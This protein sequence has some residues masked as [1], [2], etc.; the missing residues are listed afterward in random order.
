MNHIQ[1]IILAAGKSTRFNTGRTK[2]AEKICGQEII[3][4][5]TTVF[6]ELNVPTT[7]VVGY[8]QDL[9][10]EIVHAH[11]GPAFSF[12]TQ[13]EQRGSWDALQCSSTEW[14]EDHIIIMNGD[15]PLITPEIIIKLYQQHIQ[16]DADLTFASAHYH[17]PSSSYGRIVKKNGLIS[18][19]EARDF[20]GDPEED[21]C[22][23]AGIYLA[24]KDFLFSQLNQIKIN[25]TSKEFYITDLIKNASLEGKKVITVTVPFDRIRGVNTLEELWASEQIKRSEIIRHWM[26]N[27]VR[28][29]GAQNSHIDL[30]VKIGSGTIIEGGVKVRGNSVIGQNSYIGEFSS[31]E[32]SIIEDDVTI[33]A[34]CVIKHSI[35]RKQA[36]VGPFAHL[37]EH[38]HIGNHAVI[39]NFVEVK[40]ST[41]QEHSKAKHLSYIGDTQ[42]GQNVNI[43]AGTITA[44]FDGM[45]KQKT[46]VQD[47]AYIGCNTSLIAP[48]TVGHDALTA[49]GSVITE[50]V[51]ANALAIGRA[52]QINKEN[53]SPKKKQKSARDEI[54]I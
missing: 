9:L 52:R 32:N 44:N 1:A 49:A 27:G 2:L 36:Q 54:A 31:I 17:E 10:K 39:G 13:P 3:T 42:I 35:I 7:L 45:N 51:P 22:I 34:H 16:E 40:N 11:H 28:F 14:K 20:T 5:V 47:R 4:Y 6:E 43:G 8:Q 23:N 26:K 41:F 19:V 38:S 37:R 15:M 48:I 33:H 25:E 53:Y 21:C 12:V 29:S 50:D 30:S 46:I 18:I 24:K